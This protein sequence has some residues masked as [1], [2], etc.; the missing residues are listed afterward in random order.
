L[1][2]HPERP[3]GEEVVRLAPLLLLLELVGEVED[4]LELACG[5]VCN[6]REIA[7]F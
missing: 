2:D 6:P 7:S 1:K 4:A 3:A 5:P